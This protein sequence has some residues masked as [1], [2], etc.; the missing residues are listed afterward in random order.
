MTHRTLVLSLA[1]LLLSLPLA[2]DVDVLRYEL[3]MTVTAIDQTPVDVRVG[4]H[5]RPLRSID[6]LRLDIEPAVISVRS[7]RDAEGALLP[8]SVGGGKLIVAI[9]ANSPAWM[10][11]DYTIA[12]QPEN[13]QQGLFFDADHHGARLLT[14][15]SWPHYARWWLP[16]NDHPSDPASFQLKIRVPPGAFAVANGRLENMEGSTFVWE[17][18]EPIPTYAAQIVAGDLTATTMASAQFFHPPALPSLDAWIAAIRK[19]EDAVGYY[20]TAIAPYPFSKL[21]FVEAPHPFSM[22]SASISVLT[23]EETATH[24]ALHHWWGNSVQIR[25][26][27]DLW[28]SEGLTTYFTGFFDEVQGGHNTACMYR[29]VRLDVTPGRDPEHAYGIEPYCIGAAA[30]DDFRGELASL[31]G[32]SRS[33]PASTALFLDV[34]RRVYAALAFTPVDTAQFIR[35][36]QAATSAALPGVAVASRIDQWSARWFTGIPAP[37]V[38]P[39]RRAAAP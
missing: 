7:V 29:G 15:R 3:D 39:R 33:D 30:I 31:A 2:A 18:R 1:L 21:A 25:D 5:F 24:E 13:R 16:S 8:Y 34:F 14:T 11:I 28:I 19:A 35:T 37:T 26:W 10:Y 27:S 6:E 36:L 23:I 38:P 4:I 12:V 22:E 17:Q 9:S 32:L 20:S